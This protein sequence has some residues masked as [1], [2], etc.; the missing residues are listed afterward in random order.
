MSR[1]AESPLG[2]PAA[3]KFRKV[4]ETPHDISQ[5]K[6]ELS[7]TVLGFLDKYLGRVN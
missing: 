7:K 2:T 6:P 1:R 3:D 4:L 5:L